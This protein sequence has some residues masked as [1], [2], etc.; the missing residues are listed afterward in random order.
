MDF[1]P[2]DNDF[3]VFVK[4]SSQQGSLLAMQKIEENS[5]VGKWVPYEDRGKHDVCPIA[6]TGITKYHSKLL[7]GKRGKVN[8]YSGCWELAP[9]GGIDSSSSIE[10][11]LDYRQQL[12][13]E[14]EE[15][16]GISGSH[17]LKI[18]PLCLAY[19]RKI[20]LIDICMEIIVGTDILN[21]NEEYEQLFWITQEEIVSLQGGWVPLS[22]K[23]LDKEK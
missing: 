6:V 17:V 12:I 18:T 8:S 21:P 19:D 1:F 15:E 13:K 5:L 4:G 2:I 7:V 16:T 22:L 10:G 20:P 14:L 23:L 11:Y 3:E 9:S